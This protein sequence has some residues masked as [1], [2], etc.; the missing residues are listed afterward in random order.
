MYKRQ[1]CDVAQDLTITKKECDCGKAAGS[2]SLS[3]IIEGGN[4]IVSLSERA[5]G[6]VVAADVKNPITGEVIIKKSEIID[7]AGCEKIDSAGVKFINV[8]S[9]IT[10]SSKDGVCAKCYGRD[11]GRGH[12]VNRGEAVGVIS[13]VGSAVVEQKYTYAAADFMQENQMTDTIQNRRGPRRQRGKEDR[14]REK[15]P[16]KRR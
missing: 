10:C 2:I 16:I 11:L 15:K 7:E 3:E 4:V 12:I 6:R 13:R 9:V 1:L 14:S 5:L 8:H